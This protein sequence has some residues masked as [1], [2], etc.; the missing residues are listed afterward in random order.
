VLPSISGYGFFGATPIRAMNESIA[1]SLQA[2]DLTR[3]R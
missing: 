2:L 3:A 1:S